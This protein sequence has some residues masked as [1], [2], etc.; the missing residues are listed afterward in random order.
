MNFGVSWKGGWRKSIAVVSVVGASLVCAGVSWGAAT[1]KTGMSTGA[2][3]SSDAAA[4]P[5]SMYNLTAQMGASAWWDA[6]YTGQG[7][8]VAVIDTGVSPVQ[9]LNSP[10]QVV[11]GPDLSLESQNPNLT[12]LDTNGHGTFMAGLIAGHDPSLTAPYSSAPASAYRG[13]APDARI[14][15]LKVGDADGGVDVTQ[16]IAAI[17]WV[18]QHAQDP[19]FNIR[20]I[21][22][23]YGVNSTQAYTVDPLAYAIEQ[24]WKA[25][26]FVVV[27]SGNA[28]FTGGQG[29][30]MDMPALDPFVLAVG[31]SDTNGTASMSD[32]TVASFS[33]T[34]N[35]SRHV[36]LIA[37]GSH[38]VGLRDPGSY[39]DQTYGS[40][41]YVS[42]TLFRGSGTSEA[43]AIVSGAAALIIQQR[44]SITPSQLKMLLMNSANSLGRRVSNIWQGAGELNLTTALTGSSTATDSAHTA[45]TGTG[46]LE[47]SRGTDHLTLNG[48][49]LTG[50][51]DIFGQPFNAAAMA[52]AEAA[53]SSWSGGT[54]NGDTWTGSSWSG[55]SWSGVSWSGSSWSGS[56]WSGSTWSGNSWLGSSWSGSSWSGSS[57]SGSSWSGGEW[58]GGSWS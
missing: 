16:V 34:G 32:D 23:S 26:I 55:S 53:G 42:P 38:I 20:V 6:G 1:P 51:Q 5:Y 29:G 36:D 9:G 41:G 10:G 17:D 57:W 8:D 40:T 52:T 44:P 14:V 46:S 28:G 7:V 43:T 18:V 24:A 21:N 54:W 45:S 31:A 35:R 39:I 50:E 12:N 4:D 49:V 2:T 15:S 11:Y 3:A 19:G 30:S 27:A 56:S 58:A 13:I 48:V 25:G 47:L 22:L 37:P 33:S